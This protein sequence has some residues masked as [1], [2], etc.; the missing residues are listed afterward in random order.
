MAS[1]QQKYTNFTK[2]QSL[3]FA[4]KK[5]AILKNRNWR[6]YSALQGAL[7]SFLCFSLAFGP[8]YSV[9]IS[10]SLGESGASLHCHFFYATTEN[11][12]NSACQSTTGWEACYESLHVEGTCDGNI[13]ASLETVGA[14]STTCIICFII[15]VFLSA[16]TTVS[17]FMVQFIELFNISYIENIY[18]TVQSTV[19]FLH[20]TMVLVGSVTIQQTGQILE[21]S[22]YS[23]LNGAAQ[24]PELDIG[25]YTLFLI[26]IVGLLIDVFHVNYNYL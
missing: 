5:E 1:L 25:S 26:P 8:L 23:N 9:H 19:V 13:F 4:I 22:K 21:A 14:Y 17:I 15:I 6:L 3:E 10:D 2:K 20:F 16:L 11:V 24:T 7:F 12:E 18:S